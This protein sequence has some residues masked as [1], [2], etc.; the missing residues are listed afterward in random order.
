MEGRVG[1]VDDWALRGSGGE[2][3]SANV[4]G[5]STGPSSYKIT[6]QAYVL[7]SANKLKSSLGPTERFIQTL[8]ATVIGVLCE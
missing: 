1:R 2:Y 6:H 5:D 4:F 3:D 8:T 7:Q